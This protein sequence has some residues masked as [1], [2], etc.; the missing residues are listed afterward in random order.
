M[1]A[2]P[3]FARR[4]TSRSR[5]S[6]R[7]SSRS[8][9]PYRPRR[10]ASVRRMTGSA[11]R[12]RSAISSLLPVIRSDARS[13]LLMS[14]KGDL[15]RRIAAF[16]IVLM[17]AS[18]SLAQT[19]TATLSGRVTTAELPLSGV[20]VTISSPALQRTRS[21]E[22][23]DEGTYSFVAVPPGEYRVTFAISGLQTMAKSVVLHVAEVKRVDAQLQPGMSEEL[24]VIPEMSG[25]VDSIQLSTTFEQSLVNALPIGRGIT[26]ITRL[27]AGVTDNGPNRQLSIHGAPSN[28]NRSEEHTSELQ[29]RLHLVCRLL[30][31]KKKKKKKKNIQK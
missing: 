15:M 1:S 10:L 21:A 17:V 2:P 31:E 16:V 29:S 6:L 7:R 25:A 20:L 8:A 3:P 19:T 4:R 30:L 14:R 26:D 22:T 5:T 27:A 13:S 12:R 18:P 23:S 28:E 9:V 24:T 11:E